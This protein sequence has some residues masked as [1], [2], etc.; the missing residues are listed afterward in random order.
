[1]R[2]RRGPFKQGL[3]LPVLVLSV[4]LTPSLPA[5][6]ADNQIL[7]PDSNP[8]VGKQLQRLKSLIH[9]DT[10]DQLQVPPVYA[11]PL[12]IDA[13]PRVH[14]RQFII[15]GG[16]ERPEYGITHEKIHALAE[17]SRLELQQ[18]DIMNEYGLTEKDL[19]LIGRKLKD[20][21]YQDDAALQQTY[22]DILKRVRQDKKYR[23]E[24]SIGQLQEVANRLT[25]YY[26]NA[27]FVI[28]QVYVPQ[29]TVE[30]GIVHLTVSEGVLGDISVTDNKSYSAEVLSQRFQNLR[31]K[32]VQKQTLETALLSLSDYPGLIAY[33]V[34]QPGK[35]PGE[36]DLVIKVQDEQDYSWAVRAENY[37]S[38]LTGEYRLTSTL[39]LLNPLG[40]ADDLKLNLLQAFS[41]SNTLYGDLSYR[42]PI[43]RTDYL[44]GSGLSSNAFDIGGD[45][46]SSNVSGTVN[47]ANV[48][49][50]RQFIR[51]RI[52]NLYGKVD[53][54]HKIAETQ[55][56]GATFKKDTLS[57]LKLEIGFDELDIPSQA[58]NKGTVTLTQGLEDFIGSL[59]PDDALISSRTGGSGE[60]ATS[61]YLKLNWDLARLQL[62]SK[63]QNLLFRFSG[64]WTD[65]LL[66]AVE[67]TGMG[68]PANVRAFTVSEYL[69]DSAAYFSV[70]WNFNAPGFYDSPAFDNWK[71]GEILQFSVFADYAKGQL[72]DPSASELEDVELAGVGV[73]A[74]LLLPG[75]M[76][77]RLDIAMPL[78]DPLDKDD[79]QFYFTFSY[80]G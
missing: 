5:F 18:I 64:Q 4:L 60:F 15:D 43:T 69:R 7:N 6:A 29:Q 8:N 77:V 65:D 52:T 46:A 32:T 70:D 37:G 27:G 1:M 31:G 53:F 35:R 3:S 14:V 20:N 30:N 49:V 80:S 57:A 61:D 42:F 44:I 75:Q 41:P 45:L 21:L 39:S 48:F 74:Q 59:G 13:G 25:D 10:T 2:Q 72:N 78:T 67:Q 62:L 38:E 17:Q 51:S 66:V 54:T 33:G 55:I 79:V 23:E 36:S 73:A 56:G 12:G 16:V 22:S 68:G 50:S 11:R 71:W 34:L 19:E 63:Y 26:R 40:N 76:Q 47:S 28:A 9:Q 24:M 58:I